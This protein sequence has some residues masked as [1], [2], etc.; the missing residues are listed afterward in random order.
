MGAKP[1]SRRP[2]DMRA[3]S[4]MAPFLFAVAV[5]PFALGAWGCYQGWR[6]L[7]WPVT[8]AKI[9]GSD[10]RRFAL[11][12]DID[13]AYA[14]AFDEAARAGVE[15]LAWRCHTSLEE[16]VLDRQVPIAGAARPRRRAAAAG[17][18]TRV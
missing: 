11:A 12:R 9:L 2:K 10:A 17:P 1:R 8:E 15:M 7:S 16:T 5:T 13:P 6:T 18:S 3:S 14:A 4:R